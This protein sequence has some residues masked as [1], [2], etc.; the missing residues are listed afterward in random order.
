MITCLVENQVGCEHIVP[1]L[2][3]S[4]LYQ[5]LKRLVGQ[6]KSEG[7]LLQPAVF[8]LICLTINPLGLSAHDLLVSGEVVAFL[9]LVCSD[10]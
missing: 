6:K 5:S 8:L 9:V 10:V 4:L 3:S 7:Y 2:N 1:P